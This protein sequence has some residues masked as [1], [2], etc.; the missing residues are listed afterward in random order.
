MIHIQAVPI[1]SAKTFKIELCCGPTPFPGCDVALS[2]NAHFF[3]PGNCQ[4]TLTTYRNKQW[5]A[6]VRGSSFPF[7][8]GAAFEMIILI[9]PG[10][11]K[12]AVN[13]IHFAGFKHVIPFSAVTD[14]TIEG[15]IIINSVRFQVQP[16]PQPQVVYPP[17]LQSNDK[18]PVPYVKA[19]PGG[20]RAGMTFKVS[21]Y[22]LQTANDK[23][24]VSF[25]CGS[26]L[27]KSDIAF[28]FSPR[29]K[30]PLHIIRNYRVNGTWGDQD[31]TN[32]GDHDFPFPRGVLFDLVIKCHADKFRVTC[33]GKHL[34]NCPCRVMPLQR[35]VN[36]AI[37]GEVCIQ[38]VR[39]Q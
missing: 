15:E 37:I 20:L 35:I 5:V 9:E 10:N 18:F 32:Y 30:R 22:P 21:A 8:A 7:S 31:R 16:A 17:M 29:F 28:T 6:N 38:N 23:L 19:I 27:G 39:I 3:P 13:G 14:L 2:M 26:H 36:L 34:M 11:Y 1:P 24:A 4:F 33:N 25:L 12:I